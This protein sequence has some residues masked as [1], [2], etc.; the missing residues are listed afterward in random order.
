MRIISA[1]AAGAV[2]ALSACIDAEMET[3]VL[4]ADEVQVTGQM[5]MQR[6]MYDMMGGT[7]DFC[8]E[9]EGGTVEL[10]ETHAHCTITQTGTFSEIFDRGG[11]ETPTPVAT[12]L[13][14]GTVRVTFPLGDMTGEMD[15]M[16]DDPNMVAMFRPMMEGH[17]IVLRISGAEIVSSSGTISSDGTS[18]ELTIELT[19]LFDAPETIPETFEAVVRY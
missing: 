2:F 9:E 6:Q 4:G 19:D 3:T 16:I 18:T 1:A 8:P 14:D 17:S 12:D 15:E 7:T 13:G 11:E 10:T 5:Q